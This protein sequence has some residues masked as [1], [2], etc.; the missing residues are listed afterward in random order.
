M[1]IDAIT[2]SR[3][4]MNNFPTL[5]RLR[6]PRIDVY[7]KIITATGDDR[8]RLEYSYVVDMIRGGASDVHVADGLGI[9]VGDDMIIT[10]YHETVT[11]AVVPVNEASVDAFSRVNPEYMEYISRSGD[12]GEGEAQKSTTHALAYLPRVDAYIVIPAL[13][14]RVCEDDS[15]ARVERRPVNHVTV[16][17]ATNLVAFDAAAE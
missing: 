15:N 13:T 12:G 17:C 9:F 11:A 4:E 10:P 5:L 7:T 8:M 3:E 14:H 1:N 6:P 16:R 2:V